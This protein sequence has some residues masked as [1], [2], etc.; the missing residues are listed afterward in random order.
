MSDFTTLANA[1]EYLRITGTADDDMITRIITAASQ[2]MIKYM[3]RD[4]L[5]ADYTE[6]F[7]G[8]GNNFHVFGNYPVN[9]VSFVYV[10]DIPI[11]PAITD[12]SAGYTFDDEQL[13]LNGAVFYKGRINC[14][15]VY[16]AGFTEVP[17]EIEQACLELVSFKYKQIEHIDQGSKVVAGENVSFIVKDIAPFIKVILNNYKKVIC[18]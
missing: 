8:T 18:F 16:N 11:M 4:I 2:L 10:D 1:K 15:V 5:A 13:V 9:S 14:K 12:N 3:N 6:R 7:N 17:S